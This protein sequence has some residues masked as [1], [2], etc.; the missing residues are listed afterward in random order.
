MK[1]SKQNCKKKSIKIILKPPG[2]YD[3]AGQIHHEPH[4]IVKEPLDEKLQNNKLKL[5]ILEELLSVLI[6]QPVDPDYRGNARA[7]RFGQDYPEAYNS[8]IDQHSQGYIALHNLIGKNLISIQKLQ[9]EIKALKDHVDFV[10]ASWPDDHSD[11]FDPE[12]PIP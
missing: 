11:M 9:D 1:Y 2:E 4:S 6:E 10:P 12:D 7:W 8:I 3:K 5:I